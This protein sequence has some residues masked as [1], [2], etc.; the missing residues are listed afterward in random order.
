MNN[1]VKIDSEKEFIDKGNYIIVRPTGFRRTSVFCCPVCKTML[2][3]IE[4]HNEYRKLGACKNCCDRWA[5]TD[6]EAWKSGWRPT[7]KEVFDELNKRKNNPVFQIS[8]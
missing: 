7:E 2:R 6:Y 5:Y 4:D 1:W 3:G 8:F